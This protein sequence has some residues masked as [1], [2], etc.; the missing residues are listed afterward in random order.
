MTQYRVN[1]GNEVKFSICY[2]SSP[3]QQSK[4]CHIIQ[5]LLR[6]NILNCIQGKNEKAKLIFIVKT[7]IVQILN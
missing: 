4:T 3:Y 5:F 1:I 2:L 6:L 7:Y